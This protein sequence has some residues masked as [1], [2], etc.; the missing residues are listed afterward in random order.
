MATRP[1][2]ELIDDLL[3]ARKTIAGLPN[4]IEAPYEWEERLLMPLH[5][6]GVSGGVDLIVTAYP[7]FGHSKFRIMICAPKC[8]WRIDHA[9]DEPHVNSFERP[10]DLEETDFCEP[11]YHSWSDNRRFCTHGGLPDKLLNARKMPADV[12]SFDT[13]LR[14]FCGQTNIEQ[15]VVGMI[16]LPPRRRL[17]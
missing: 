13:S 15:P 1:I 2:A 14:W 12:R 6:N 4:W 7:H 5:I 10:L 16:T 3:A 8:I 11:H 17:I 9:N